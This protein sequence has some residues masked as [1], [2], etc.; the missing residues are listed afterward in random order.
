MFDLTRLSW[1]EIRV[2]AAGFAFGALFQSVMNPAE[3]RAQGA[4]YATEENILKVI[5]PLF[6]EELWDEFERIRTRRD[7]HRTILLK[8]FQR[9]LGA[10]RFL[11]RHADAATSW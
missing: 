9:K 8:G 4:H 10:M 2:R 11:T 6:L 7:T 3:R 1:N 5:R